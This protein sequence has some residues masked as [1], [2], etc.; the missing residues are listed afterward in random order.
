MFEQ[1][2][3]FT[4][5]LHD[6]SNWL[7]KTIV[8]VQ[9]FHTE[10]ILVVAVLRFLNIIKCSIGAKAN[11]HSHIGDSVRFCMF[12]IQHA[13]H[14]FAFI[15]PPNGSRSSSSLRCV[16]LTKHKPP[17]TNRWRFSHTHCSICASHLRVCA[18]L[19]ISNMVHDTDERM[20]A[21]NQT[22]PPKNV[23]LRYRILYKFM[24]ISTKTQR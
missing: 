21:H 17:T 23:M 10:W 12:R 13:M 5:T 4:C 9:Q 19:S 18:F 2:L 14:Q 15:S 22:S 6:R 24:Q 11:V 1:F 7:R 16:A 8:P 20:N 3:F